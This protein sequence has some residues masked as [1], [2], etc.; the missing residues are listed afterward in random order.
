[1]CDMYNT[2]LP[3]LL[4]AAVKGADADEARRMYNDADYCSRKLLDGIMSTGRLLSGVSDDADLHRDDLRCM[5][6][7]IA[8]TAELV[9]AFSDVAEAY[10]YRIRTGEI[11]MNA[12]RL[13]EGGHHVG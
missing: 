11:T 6:D 7:A 8:V 2:G 1:M 9:A 13:N 3:A 4:V 10:H 12:P 5:G